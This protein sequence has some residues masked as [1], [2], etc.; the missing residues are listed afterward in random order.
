MKTADR[1]SSLLFRVIC[2]GFSLVLL[3]MSLLGQIRLV[4]TESR[5]EALRAAVQEAE[6]TN[7]VLKTRLAESLTLPEL[8]RIALQD[9][10]MQH[11]EPGQITT[12]G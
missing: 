11:P 12:L 6:N 10:G 3:V 4:E 5:V 7:T 1:V 2:L 8:E 9:F